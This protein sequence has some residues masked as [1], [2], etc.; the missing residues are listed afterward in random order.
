MG[1]TPYL[2]HNNDDEQS[3]AHE[4]QSSIESCSVKRLCGH[5]ILELDL[6]WSSYD[7][8]L[9]HSS[10]IEKRGTKTGHGRL[11]P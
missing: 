4:Y 10:G 1:G 5:L 11:L 3:Q 6:L 9:V 7:G 8:Q 2:N